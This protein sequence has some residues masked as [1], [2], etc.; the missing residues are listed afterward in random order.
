MAKALKKCFDLSQVTIVAYVDSD[1]EKHGKY[2]DN[3]EIISPLD[4][5]NLEFDLIFISSVKYQDEIFV[6]LKKLGINRSKIVLATVTNVEM[7]N[8]MDILT[9]KGMLYLSHIA[10]TVRQ[11]IR[12]KKIEKKIDELSSIVTKRD[13]YEAFKSNHSYLKRYYEDD[14][15]E[16]IAN[17]FI[18]S[19]D[20]PGK[21]VLFDS[22]RAYFDYVIDYIP[23]KDGLYL[24]FGVWKGDSINYIAGQIGS[25]IVYGFD[26]FEGL[27]EDWLPGCDT[28]LHSTQGQL[29]N[30]KDNVELVKGMFD[31]TLPV[32][33]EKHRGE[34][35]SFIHIDSDLYSSAKYV[36]D[37]LKENI[38]K[39]TIICFDEFAGHIGWR[40]DEYKAFMEFIEET[41]YKYRYIAGSYA[42]NSCRN[43]E[44][45]AIE[46]L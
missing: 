37:M 41:G 14:A 32:F 8:I 12:Y 17:A 30:V 10:T 40:D 33:L 27:P 7:A 21:K 1:V 16:F 6:E 25:K 35:C 31:E 11:E 42:T 4:L 38:G 20:A 36:L 2:L 39:G 5:L 34:Q 3:A 15:A 28:S 13:K 9:D 23:F 18:E 44:R 43:G 45:V 29:P 19:K 46:I 24:E 26:C 22:R